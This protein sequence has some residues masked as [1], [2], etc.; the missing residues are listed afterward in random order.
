M[1][2][3]LRELLPGSSRRFEH[4]YHESLYRLLSLPMDRF[5]KGG[6]GIKFVSVYRLSI[7]LDFH[8]GKMLLALS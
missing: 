8:G 4:G 7:S 6:S 2:R 1:L 3:T 5:E